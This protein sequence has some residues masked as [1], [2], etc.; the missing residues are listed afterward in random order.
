VQTFIPYDDFYKSAQ[1]LDRQRLGK[2]RVETLQILNA[3]A[4][5]S[6]GWV[7]HPATK[8]WRSHEP[9]LVEYGIVICQEWKMR[10][11]KDSCEEKIW[12]VS[13]NFRPNKGFTL[14][15]PWW[16]SDKV[17]DSHKSKLI[18]KDSEWYSQFGWSVP[19]DLEYVW[20]V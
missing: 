5:L 2:Q 1:C 19:H 9:S 17:H 15:P 13:K 3:L 10:G 20:P 8:M 14:L 6:K 12:Q 4:G 7:N 18:Q 16:G 11:Y